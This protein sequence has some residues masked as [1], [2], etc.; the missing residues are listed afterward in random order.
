MRL[1]GWFLFVAFVPFYLNVSS[2]PGPD[3]PPAPPNGLSLPP[4]PDQGQQQA[5]QSP[6]EQQITQPTA[7]A[8][9]EAEKATTQSSSS[10]DLKTTQLKWPDALELNEEKSG[11]LAN[12]DPEI[13]KIYNDSE[14]S[15][16]EISKIVQDISKM[17]DDLFAKLTEIS[18]KADDFFQEA[19]IQKGRLSE[20]N[21]DLV[22]K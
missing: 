19:T 14:S 15:L 22:V 12:S 4:Q 3:L 21:E 1:G 2:M 5:A 10:V 6:A 7:A 13:I 11:L 9:P 20:A 18:N 8:S 17:R 16:N